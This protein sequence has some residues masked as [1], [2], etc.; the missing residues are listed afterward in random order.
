MNTNFIKERHILILYTGGTI[1]M[2]KGENGLI[3]KKNFLYEYMMNH[4]NLCDK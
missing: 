2:C 1:G 3:P 4:P